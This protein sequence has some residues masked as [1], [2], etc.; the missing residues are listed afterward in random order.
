MRAHGA[1]LAFMNVGRIYGKPVI[2]AD[3][4]AGAAVKK[5]GVGG[6]EPHGAV[7]GTK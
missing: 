2:A 1:W 4:E 7:L 3:V 6:V 5:P